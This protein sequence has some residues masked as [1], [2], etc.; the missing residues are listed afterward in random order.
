[1]SKNSLC[2]QR[3]ERMDSVKYCLI[4]LV[5]IGHI[6]GNYIFSTPLERVVNNWIYIFH[7]PLFVFISGYFSRK[8]D[9]KHFREGCY[10][11]IEPLIVF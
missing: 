10:K 5:I 2:F 3:D 4:V 8:K 11:L 7:M 6:F 1:M 9:S